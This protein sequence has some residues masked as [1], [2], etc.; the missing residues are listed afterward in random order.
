MHTF[1]LPTLRY[2]IFIII[3]VALNFSGGIRVTVFGSNLDSVYEPYMT[4]TATASDIDDLEFKAAA[5][6]RML[7][8]TSLLYEAVTPQVFIRCSE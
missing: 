3:K 4:I 5:V 8:D 7:E 2:Y 6:S 1:V